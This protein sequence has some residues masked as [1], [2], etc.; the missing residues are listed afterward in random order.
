MEIWA[1]FGN[2]KFTVFK[3]FKFVEEADDHKY[4]GNQVGNIIFFLDN[5]LSMT[6]SLPKYYFLIIAVVTW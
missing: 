2:L 3:N 4:F 1:A 5:F 6:A